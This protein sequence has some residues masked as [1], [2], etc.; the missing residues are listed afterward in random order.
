MPEIDSKYLKQMP[1]SDLYGDEDGF[2]MNIDLDW[3]PETVEPEEEKEVGEQFNEVAPL[4]PNQL[5]FLAQQQ[6]ERTI[7]ISEG[8]HL[9]DGSCAPMQDTPRHK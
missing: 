2:D 5:D 3:Q 1:S 9:V 8:S 6:W 7:Q 4:S